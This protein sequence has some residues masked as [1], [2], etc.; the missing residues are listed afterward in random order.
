V[1]PSTHMVSWF[2]VWNGPDM[3]AVLPEQNRCL[4]IKLH[5]NK[6]S[7]WNSLLPNFLL[8]YEINTC[9]HLREV[10]GSQDKR[11]WMRNSG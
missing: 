1:A 2:C 8:S 6:S 4:L 7:L 3:R 9:K 5:L 10:N 11:R